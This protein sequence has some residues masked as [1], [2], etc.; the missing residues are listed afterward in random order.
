MTTT[1]NIRMKQRRK[2]AADWTS[3]NEVLL[4]GEI[5]LETD[6]R[7]QKFGDGTTAWNSLAYSA[8]DLTGALLTSQLDTD[9]A[10]A[11][12]SDAKVPSQKA[13]KT[14]VDTAV[15]GLLD[16]KGATDCSGNPN[17]PA[18]LKGD[19]YIVSVAGKIGGA[20]GTTVEVG[21]MFVASADNAGGTQASV[22]TSWA[23]IE[24]NLPALGSMATQN[25]NAVTITGGTLAGMTSIGLT[26]SWAIFSTSGTLRFYRG[27]DVM[28]L[29][30]SAG[31]TLGILTTGALYKGIR[32]VTAAPTISTSDSTVLC[33]ATSAAFSVVLP[34][35]SGSSGRV[36]HIKKIDSSGNAVTV[37]GNA[38]ETIDG[39]T[40]LVLAAQWD[41]VTIQ[42][43]SGAWYII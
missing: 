9:G 17:Y 24:H 35:A 34:A 21:D 1:F 22:G 30:T 28:T 13:V 11:A 4:A 19:V 42:C 37:D 20:S 32:T 7:K 39:A 23:V 10:L 43:V 29:T 6:T 14:Y 25:A 31:L 26:D 3:A 5:G 8:M 40:T 15:T 41:A 2:V 16:F 27:G 33:D 36:L 18:A 38:S 12:N